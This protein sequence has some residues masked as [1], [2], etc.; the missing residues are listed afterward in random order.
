MYRVLT[1]LTAEHDLRLVALAAATCT[2]AAFTAFAIYAQA[3][4]NSGVKR[5]GW[6]FLTAV[7]SACGIW[8]THFIAMLAYDPGLP[9]AYE[10][11]R[12]IASLLIAVAAT[13]LGFGLASFPGLAAQAAGGALIG[14]GISLMHYTGMYAVM[15]PG[16][17][18]WDAALV[19]ASIV[20]GALLSALAVVA[21]HRLDQRRATWVASALF[22]LA[23]CGM[24]FTAMGAATVVPDPTV[25]FLGSPVDNGLIAA[26][27]AG[28]AVIILLAGATPALIAGQTAREA[29]SEKLRFQAA[30]DKMSQGLCMVDASG[31]IQVCNRRYAEMYQ[32]PPELTRPGTPLRD[33]SRYRFATGSY[34]VGAQ[35]SDIGSDHVLPDMIFNKTRELTDGR[36]ISVSRRPLPNGGWV[37]THQDVTDIRRAEARVAHL[38]HHDALTDL[39]NRALLRQRMEEAAAGSR[40]GER[41]L[42]VLMLDLDRFKEVND[43][44]GHAFGDALLKSVAERLKSCV[45]EGDTVAR[46][47]GDEFAVLQLVTD[48]AREAEALANRIIEKIS[49]PYDLDG[50]QALIGTSIGI[51]LA[52][53]DGTE[54]D[55]LLKAADLALY[56]AKS[57]GRGTYCFFEPEMDER[58][59]ARRT[60]EKELRAA[61]GNGEFELY[62][63]PLV[64]LVDDEIC[65]FE[66]LLRWNHPRRG[67]LSP[68]EF[69]PLAE[70]TGLIVP[71]GEWVLRKACAEAANWPHHLKVSVNVS[72]AQFKSQNL[73]SAVVSALASSGLEPGRLEVEVTESVV[74]EDGE[75]AFRTLNQLRAIGVRIAL[76][77]FGT[78]Y[79][80]LTNL[81]KFPFDKIK[82]DKSFVSD[83][84]AANVNALAIVRSVARLGVSLGMATTAEGVETKEQVEQV[85]AEGCTEMQ[86]YYIC[87]PSPASVIAELI[88]TKIKPK[89]ASA[90]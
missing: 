8:A 4:D 79:S 74:L 14:A 84:S 57:T 29:I 87:P 28:V 40:R 2:M 15:L 9:V 62:Y 38:A 5:L 76:D 32:L 7:V 47:G 80:S 13:G 52:P 82:I 64:N 45:R 83:L 69:V 54:P 90:A 73:V 25:P 3:V 36:I 85:R 12:T 39:P 24:H 10:P 6:L 61:I 18:E 86:G 51:A 77:D 26:S 21:Y 22:A 44:L 17:L 60:L 50:H 33:I 31:R 11:V 59:Q 37:T 48:P 49:A 68:S 23:I 81:R 78:G 35:A 41:S 65:G 34:Y 55:Q 70:E 72:V 75:A 30:L 43:T 1:C 88:Q 16:R 67:L 71:I 19:V 66:A 20:I 58:M 89:T 63:Q 27:I 56:R 53:T 42:A 46:L